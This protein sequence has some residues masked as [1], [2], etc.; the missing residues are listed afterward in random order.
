M[1][2]LPMAVGAQRDEVINPADDGHGRVFGKCSDG[3]NVANFDVFI[4]AAVLAYS[5]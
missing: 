4:V 2:E 1:V 5:W 3:L